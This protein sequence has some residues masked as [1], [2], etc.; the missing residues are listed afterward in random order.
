MAILKSV[1]YSYTFFMCEVQALLLFFQKKKYL[2]MLLQFMAIVFFPG[3]CYHYIAYFSVVINII[4]S[5]CNTPLLYI[6]LHI[7]PYAHSFEHGHNHYGK[8]INL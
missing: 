4:S 6:I 7:S 8:K 1:Q 3:A 5:L 2:I